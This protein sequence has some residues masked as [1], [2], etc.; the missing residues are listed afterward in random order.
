VLFKKQSNVTAG[1]IINP[2]FKFHFA[3]TYRFAEAW[4]SLWLGNSNLH[5]PGWKEIEPF[6][7]VG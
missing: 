1:E 6:L 5:S 7:V 3:F 4:T 2:N